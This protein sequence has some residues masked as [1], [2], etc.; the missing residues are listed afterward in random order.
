MFIDTTSNCFSTNTEC[1]Y[2]NFAFASWY[3]LNGL[4]HFKEKKIY[5]WWLYYI[6]SRIILYYT[7]YRVILSNVWKCELHITISK[8]KMCDRLTYIGKICTVFHIRHTRL[9]RH[10]TGFMNT[11]LN[12]DFSE[13]ELD[14]KNPITSLSGL[15]QI[16]EF[17]F[18]FVS[19][20]I[21]FR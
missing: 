10:G 2:R 8:S 5:S 19:I 1:I 11:G 12:P 15:K 21:E 4:L 9:W 16:S 14:F 13:S 6:F 18:K 3:P 7:V 17:E 20:R